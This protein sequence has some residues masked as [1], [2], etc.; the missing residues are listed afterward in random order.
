MHRAMTLLFDTLYFAAGIPAL[1]VSLLRGRVARTWDHL[2]RRALAN[3]PERRGDGP[4]LWL[5]G[6]SVGE[7]L[8]ARRLVECIEDGFPDWDVVISSSTRLGVEAAS[9]EF[10]GHTV[11][12]YPLDIGYLVRSAFR[13]LR[14][15]VIIIVEHDLWPNFLR[16][17]ISLDV[18]VA[19]VN[20][21]LSPRSLRGYRR[22]SRIYTWPPRELA[23]LCVQDELSAQGFRKLGFAA[24]RR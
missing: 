21:R 13:R 19:L 7:V 16:H 8:S 11:F 10:S 12:S 14:P 22:L 18:P 6:V 20:A 9:R 3:V 4:C 24:D 17:A 2:R 23:S 15:D 5:H 1:F